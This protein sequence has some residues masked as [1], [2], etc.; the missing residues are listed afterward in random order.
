[1]KIKNLISF[2][3]ILSVLSVMLS[4]G[5][6]AAAPSYA[7]YYSYEINNRD[8][9]VAAPVGFTE[10]FTANSTSLGLDVHIDSPE[11]FVV[12]SE[13]FF[14]LD[15]G[16]SRIIALDKALK[17]K[18]IYSDFR[19]ENNEP[20]D[21]KGA[22]GFDIDRNGNFVIADT[23][24]LRILILDRGGSL[25]RQILKP[26]AVLENNEFPF[27]VTK[28][29]CAEDGNIY[30]T[31]ETMNLG[32]FVFDEN[33]SFDKFVANNP[34][35]ATSEVILNYIY[36]AFLTTEQIRNRMQAT[37]LKVNNFCMDSNGFLYTVSQSVYS[38]KQSGMVRCM[39][40]R[41]SN[42]INSSIVF[43][44]VE[45]DPTY[46]TTLFS[47]VSVTDNGDYVLLDSGRGKV[48]YYDSNGNL[49]SVFGGYGDQAGTFREPV[50][51]RYSDGNIYVLDKGK[52]SLTEFKPTEYVI[53]YNKALSLLKERKF[54]ESLEEWKNVVLLNSNSRYAY[55]GMGLV[56]D[57][58][59]DYASAMDCFKA[60]DNRTAYSN[61]FK[62]YRAE[63][64]E[65]NV[66]LIVFVIL[67]VIAV[68][69][70][71]VLSFKKLRA[72][73]GTAYS[74]M[75][76]KSLFPLYTL[77][78]PIDGF[79]QFKT[80]DVASLPIA[81]GIIA[82]WLITEIASR[83]ALGF[84]YSPVDSS[85]NPM[86]IIAGT[87]GLFVIFVASNWGV[88]SF[89]EGK[90]T[91][92]DII[93]TVA[94]SLIPYIVSQIIRIPL[95][96]ILTLDES[97]FISIISAIGLIWSGILLLGGLYAIHQYSFTKTLGSL[98]LTAIGM[99]IILL[100]AVIFASLMQQAFGFFDSLRQELTL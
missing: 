73:N 60:A 92:K 93:V 33:G 70:A 17:L 25:K 23:E 86:A 95:T 77:R 89:I 5:C 72:T 34:T 62:E 55:Y 84:I 59:G 1:M 91:F 8:E 83:Y 87:V 57:M 38:T 4:V 41:D 29:K 53:T 99:L 3:L 65:K 27:R 61:S 24:N 7:P 64:T 85:F 76:R 19:D 11:D 63:W 40:F 56:Y 48:F 54:D 16:N 47:S 20:L 97:V 49:I 35:I 51:V 90:G 44:D 45:A 66:V 10:A 67:A 88:A 18:R 37:P 52:N 22:V 6:S 68:I 12:N 98:L 50:E 36:R 46:K 94:Y 96:N 80:R 14:I 78:H 21:F 32:I 74:I 81:V 31:V 100:V 28:L 39:N 15:S 42:I 43:G 69:T 30:V 2:V 9:S 79:E 26:E 75:E 82:A 13:G 58:K 71:V